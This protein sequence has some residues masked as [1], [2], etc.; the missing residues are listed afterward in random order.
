MN[1]IFRAPR[2]R[3]L[4]C[5][6]TLAA[7]LLGALAMAPPAHSADLYGYEGYPAPH[8]YQGAAYRS[9]LRTMRLR[10]LRVLA[11][12]LRTPLRSPFPAAPH[13]R[14]ARHQPRIL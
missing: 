10:A 12:R 6:A 1:R 2:R 9:R 11:M 5:I 3:W 14:T 8:Y 13:S 7:A 4:A